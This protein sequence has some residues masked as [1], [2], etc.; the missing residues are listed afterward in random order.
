MTLQ[1][2]QGA[3]R[4]LAVACA[5]LAATTLAA[6]RG[7]T[8]TPDLQGTWDTGTATPL[9]RPAPFAATSHFTRAEADA[10]ER[11]NYARILSVFSKE[12][13]LASDLN[14]TYQET[15]DLKV[16]P[17]LRTSLIIDPPNGQLPDLLP[18]AQARMAAR[19]KRNYDD[20]ETLT[21]DERCLAGV[22]FSSSSATPPLVPNPFGQNLYQIVQTPDRVLIFSELIHDARVVRLGGT[23]LPPSIRL[24]TGDSIGHWDGDTLVVDTT[25]FRREKSFRG[26]SERMHV[27]ERFTRLSPDMLRYRVTVEDPDT[28]A[29]PWTAEIPFRATTNQLFEYACHEGNRTIENFMR[30]ARDEERRG[31]KPR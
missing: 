3:S 22:N 30:G 7:T 24:W 17:D 2:R 1:L 4:L 15:A 10:F 13:L 12:D 5:C 18:Q 26:S 11:D 28:W 19:P 16:V 8:N 23:H 31:V 6:Q 9:I 29:T 21:L 27:V 20:P 14:E 25:N